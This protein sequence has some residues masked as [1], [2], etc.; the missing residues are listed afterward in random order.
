M[1]TIL[2]TGCAGFIGSHL[3]EKLLEQGFKVLGLDNL[4]NGKLTNIA[5]IMKNKNF[6]FLKCDINDNK[7]S[8]SF[9]MMLKLFINL[10]LHNTH[11]CTKYKNA[12]HSKTKTY[13]KF[14][15]N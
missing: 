6:K 12:E 9:L 8:M 14:Y 13:L 10:L 1:N 3:S 15:F 4:S 5:S 11:S 7:I 2:V